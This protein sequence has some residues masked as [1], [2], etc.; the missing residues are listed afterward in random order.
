M[1]TSTYQHLLGADFQVF[2]VPFLLHATRNLVTVL[3]ED[4]VGLHTKASQFPQSKS[5][6]GSSGPL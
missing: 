2:C 5:L 1:L 6:A 3:E 4:I